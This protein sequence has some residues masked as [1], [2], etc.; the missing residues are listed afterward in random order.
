MPSAPSKSQPSCSTT[1]TTKNIYTPYG[2]LVQALVYDEVT[3]SMNYQT[4]NYYLYDEDYDEADIIYLDIDKPSSSSIYN[5][6]G[7]AWHMTPENSLEPDLDEG[8][9]FGAAQ[10]KKYFTD[11]ASYKQVDSPTYPGWIVWQNQDHTA[12]T[13]SSSNLYRWRS[14]WGCGPL[15][16]HDSVTTPYALSEPL[17]FYKRCYRKQF[18]KDWIVDD[19]LSVCKHELEDCS[20]GTNVDLTIE[21]E[22]WL[23]IT[24]IFSTGSGA[25]L[26][27]CPEN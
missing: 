15:M 6:H 3:E 20:V 7:Y 21:Y 12:R 5:C 25:E 24:G 26:N 2:V 19:T 9:T 10:A 18:E 23:K 27:F 8:V 16:E 11:G 1:Y 17:K 22:D 14:K 4:D 13:I